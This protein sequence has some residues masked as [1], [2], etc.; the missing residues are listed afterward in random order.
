MPKPPKA[1]PAPVKPPAARPKRVSKSAAAVPA[2][3][4]AE[5]GIVRRKPDEMRKE[6]QLHIRI[7]AAQR[8]AMA[9][10]ATR[11]GMDLSAW[12]RWVLF[13]AAGATEA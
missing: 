12:V 8:E 11:E 1:R 13:K 4:D 7:T 5:A 10:A 6:S 3:G 9:R 2:E